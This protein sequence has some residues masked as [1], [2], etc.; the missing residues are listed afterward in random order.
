M[1]NLFSLIVITMLIG[2]SDP[3]SKVECING[4]CT[5]GTCACSEGWQG[6][7]C[8]ERIYRYTGS[9]IMSALVAKNCSNPR[10]ST[11]STGQLCTAPTGNRLCLKLTIEITDDNRLVMRTVTDTYSGGGGI[12][13]TQTG[14]TRGSY[15]ISNNMLAFCPDNNPSMCDRFMIDDNSSKLTWLLGVLSD[16]CDTSYELIRN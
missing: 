11:T 14:V 3:C 9:W 8:D 10:T 16:G 15:T 12:R 13:S 6:N 7:K 2:C 1:K 4:S 5:D